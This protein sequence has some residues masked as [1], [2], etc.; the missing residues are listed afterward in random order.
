M[1]RRGTPMS[2][3]VLN[4]SPVTLNGCHLIAVCQLTFATATNLYFINHAGDSF[5]SRISSVMTVHRVSI[6]SR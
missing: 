3:M 6:R 5:A 2:A 4:G 1:G